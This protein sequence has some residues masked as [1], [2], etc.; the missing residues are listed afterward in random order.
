MR[1]ADVQTHLPDHLA[2]SLP[3]ATAEAVAAHLRTCEACAAEFEAAEDTWNRLEVIRSP[4]ADS[5]AMRTR[6][7][8]ALDEYQHGSAAPRR[9]R[10]WL[11]RHGVQLAAAAAVLMVGVLIGRGLTPDPA[12]DPQIGEMRAELREMREMVTLSL[13][14]QQSASERL[15]GITWTRQID[16]PGNDVTAALLDA[17]THDPNVNVRLAS[18]DAL[19]RF[20]ERD[21]VRRGAID[22]LAQQTSPFV[23]IALIDF[24]LEV[25]G[26]EAADALRRLSMD[27]MV[28][29]AV[30]A[31]AARGL[32]RLG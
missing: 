6:F 19:R 11:A 26:R 5:A 18:I 25:T 15:K 22:A 29:E 32:E 9:P 21:A 2:R 20:A 1:C 4:R 27:P 3:A 17:L 31:R 30:R 23:Q 8:A 7:D 14:Q 16:A 10:G 28:D 12:P 13:L 24:V